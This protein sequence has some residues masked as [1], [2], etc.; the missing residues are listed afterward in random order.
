[1]QSSILKAVGEEKIRELWANVHAADGDLVLI[2]A[3]SRSQSNAALGQLRLHLARQE[4]WYTKDDFA[5][6]WVVDFPLFEFDSEENRFVACH[7]PFT[8]PMPASIP[9]L[10][11]DP[12]KAAAQAYDVVCNGYEI[13]GGSVRIHSAEVQSKVFDT[14][15][16]TREEAR[17]KFGFL[18]DA[19]QYGAPP[20]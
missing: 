16:I 12:G 10:D 18:L 1:F 5:F 8:S 3:G 4:K 15:R 2:V 20:H 19:L 9:L 14:L 13:G 11:S 7:H 6:E 17:E